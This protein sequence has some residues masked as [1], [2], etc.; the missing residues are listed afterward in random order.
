MTVLTLALSTDELDD[1]RLQRDVHL[2]I[3]HLFTTT[4]IRNTSQIFV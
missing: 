2:D 1:A 4:K 3:P